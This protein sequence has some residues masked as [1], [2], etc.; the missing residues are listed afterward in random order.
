MQAIL[1]EYG[2]FLNSTNI[3][4]IERGERALSDVELH[5]F[6]LALDVAVA[7]LIAEPVFANKEDLINALKSVQRRGPGKKPKK[8]R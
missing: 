4:R 7:E 8:K 5:V 1:E 3:G 6:A 2:Y